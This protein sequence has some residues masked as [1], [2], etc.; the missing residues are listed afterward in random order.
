MKPSYFTQSL[1]RASEQ[2]TRSQIS[3]SHRQAHLRKR[4]KPHEQH[5]T[6]CQ[7]VSSSGRLRENRHSSVENNL[8]K[9]PSYLPNSIAVICILLHCLPLPLF[10]KS[11]TTH[12]RDTSRIPN[13]RRT[14][15]AIS[16]AKGSMWSTMP[17]CPSTAI[18]SQANTSKTASAQRATCAAASQ[19]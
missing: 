2:K 19:P 3:S 15:P 12:R 6:P 8:R 4:S 17:G 11:N 16:V 5:E 10:R 7:R 13:C 9:N 14:R 1:H 18:A